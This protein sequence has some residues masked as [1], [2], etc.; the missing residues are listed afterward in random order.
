MESSMQTI[1]HKANGL[2][3]PVTHAFA[4]KLECESVYFL[5]ISKTCLSLKNAWMDK[6]HICLSLSIVC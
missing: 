3:K 1:K 6:T 2:K 5:F 4:N